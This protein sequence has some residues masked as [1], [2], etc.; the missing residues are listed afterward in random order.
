VYQRGDIWW[1]MVLSMWSF[2]VFKRWQDGGDVMARNIWYFSFLFSCFSLILWKFVAPNLYIKY[3]IP[4]LITLRCSRAVGVMVFIVNSQNYIWKPAS[5]QLGCPLALFVSQYMKLAYLLCQVLAHQV[6]LVHHIWLVSLN[7]LAVLMS[8]PG[9]CEAECSLSTD[10]GDCS[11]KWLQKLAVLDKYW[12]FSATNPA[13]MGND[14]EPWQACTIIQCFVAVGYI[15]GVSLLILKYDLFEFISPC[16]FNLLQV[17]FA[18]GPPLM[19]YA[20]VEEHW[21]KFF[22]FW[23]GGIPLIYDLKITL[24]YDTLLS[25]LAVP[26]IYAAI[27]LVIGSIRHVF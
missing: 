12:I 18:L 2:S 16:S 8:V 4:L 23:R 26:I 14:I 15:L 9:R 24:F 27:S 17:L 5:R 11:M 7:G 1:F 6:P 25:L 20:T 22:L 13:S 3:R 21:R 10:F 19:Y